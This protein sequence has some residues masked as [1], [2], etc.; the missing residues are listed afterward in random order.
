MRIFFIVVIVAWNL[1]TVMCC[2][3]DNV[4]SY[5]K[6]DVKKEAKKYER[7]G[8]KSFVGQPP[9]NQQLDK[10]WRMQAEADESGFPKWIV[11]SGHCISISKEQA[12]KHGIL[13]AKHGLFEI[14]HML[15]EA[16]IKSAVNSGMLQP[17]DSIVLLKVHREAE[18]MI[19]EYDPILKS[20]DNFYTEEGDTNFLEYT[21]ET[22]LINRIYSGDLN[23]VDELVIFHRTKSS[24]NPFTPY[25]WLDDDELI[26]SLKLFRILEAPPEYCKQCTAEVSV[27][28]A[29]SMSQIESGLQKTFIQ[30][31][32]DSSQ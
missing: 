5:T 23:A 20:E 12:L 25:N 16:E 29:C 27:L 11:S 7:D 9:I 18:K 30:Y 3:Q 1:F 28:L 2:A 24:I 4:V 21:Q 22:D 10:S 14:L 15:V 17:A 13:F 6:S 26:V 31:L 19:S 8:Y 32:E